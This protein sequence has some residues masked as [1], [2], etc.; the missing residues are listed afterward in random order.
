MRQRSGL[1]VVLVY[2]GA[3]AA[4]A[5]SLA[6]TYTILVYAVERWYP[7]VDG[8][9]LGWQLTLIGLAVSPVMFGMSLLVGVA[10]LLFLSGRMLRVRD[11]N[12]SGDNG[13]MLIDGDASGHDKSGN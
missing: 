4:A 2:F 3:I 12:S 6:I 5:A 1:S 11:P 13:G 7:D 8:E 10:T 9:T